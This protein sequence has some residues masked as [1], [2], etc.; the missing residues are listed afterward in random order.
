MASKFGLEEHLI[1][2]YKDEFSLAQKQS[3]PYLQELLSNNWKYL[4]INS[5]EL[6]KAC[7]TSLLAT[8]CK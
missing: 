8:S 1:T 7:P 2:I 3:R 5:I 6:V 4:N